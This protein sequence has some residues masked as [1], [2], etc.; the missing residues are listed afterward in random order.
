MP[1]FII[2]LASKFGVYGLAAI[3]SGG[4]PIANQFP[5]WYDQIGAGRIGGQSGVPIPAII[6]IVS[7]IIVLFIMENTTTGRSTYAVGGNPESARLSGI[8]VGKTIVI[9]LV[10]VQILSV[11]SGFMTSG[12]VWRDPTP[13]AAGGSW[14]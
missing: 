14:T 2:T 4:Y 3:I 5:D 12:Q 7:F 9:A 1:S 11:I 13:S 6:L 10:A 8:N